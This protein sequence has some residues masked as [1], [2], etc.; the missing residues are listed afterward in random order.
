[1]TSPPPNRFG[2]RR[3]G[4]EGLLGQTFPPGEVLQVDLLPAALDQRSS[5]VT[6]DVSW[7]AA[8]RELTADGSFLRSRKLTW[9]CVLGS[10]YIATWQIVTGSGLA[11]VAVWWLVGMVVFG[12]LWLAPD[13]KPF[14]HAR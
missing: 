3:R 5:R 2:R 10:G 14:R 7:T 8:L 1:M 9:T 12:L 13:R 6:G 11:I 4:G